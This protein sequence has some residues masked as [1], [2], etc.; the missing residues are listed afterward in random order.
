MD[1]KSPSFGT[2]AELKTWCER[3]PLGT[4]LEAH[5][6]GEILAAAV[7][8]VDPPQDAQ[9][10]RGAPPSGETWREKLWTAPAETRLGVKEVAQA[11]GRPKSWVYA[12]T[13]TKAEAPIPHRKL[14][15]SLLF[16]AGELRA[17]MRSREEEVVGG[18]MES[19]ATD[20]RLR[21]V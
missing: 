15:G 14:D 20:R 10:D 8:R 21:A 13:A 9:G 6:V 18:P 11:L 2:V 17:W 16:T 12:K 3:A 5:V 19:P 7:D 1:T 4:L